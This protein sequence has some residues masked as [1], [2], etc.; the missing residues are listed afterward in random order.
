MGLEVD[1]PAQGTHFP[2]WLLKPRRRAERAL[3]AVVAAQPRAQAADGRHGNL[4]E[5]P[6]SLNLDAPCPSEGEGNRL[7]P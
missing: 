6:G 7:V 5:S 1:G 2:G 3:V 4:P